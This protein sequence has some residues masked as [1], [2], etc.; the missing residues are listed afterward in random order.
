M[1][2][3]VMREKGPAGSCLTQMSDFAFRASST[4]IARPLGESAR[5]LIVPS[6]FH[7]ESTR[8]ASPSRVTQTI[9]R[10]DAWLAVW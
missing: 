8:L 3:K 9:S 1:S 2:P 4:A 5:A 6:S 7:A 10:D